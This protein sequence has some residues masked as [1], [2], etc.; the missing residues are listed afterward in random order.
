MGSQLNDLL[1][2]INGYI[3]S[4]IFEN[5]KMGIQEALFWSIKIN[6]QPIYY[7]N[8][9]FDNPSLGCEFL[10]ID[11]Q[12]WNKLDN[13][14]LEF[15]SNKYDASF[16]LYTHDYARKSKIEFS[17]KKEVYFNVKYEM[18]VDFTGVS[19]TDTDPN[20]LISVEALLPYIGFT[21]HPAILEP[22]KENTEKA[23]ILASKYVD[24]G[25]FQNAEIAKSGFK[26]KPKI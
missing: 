14:I 11:I 17:R 16:Y 21:I 22:I 25:L 7:Q 2:P 15:D 12:D 6:F 13:M 23:L 9:H 5:P 8:E 26:F 3:S 20:L 10:R 1:Y 18:L 4:M 24:L 19:E